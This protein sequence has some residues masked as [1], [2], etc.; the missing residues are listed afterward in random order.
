MPTTDHRREPDS[1]D[2]GPIRP[3]SPLHDLLRLVAR[4]IAASLPEAPNPGGSDPV[5][6]QEQPPEPPPIDRPT[7]AD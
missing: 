4:A 3:G 1:P 6:R 5:A 2:K 7:A